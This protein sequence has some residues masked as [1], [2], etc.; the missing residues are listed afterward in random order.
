MHGGYIWPQAGTAYHNL[1]AELLRT[2]EDIAERIVLSTLP[3]I[4]VRTCY[5]LDEAEVVMYVYI[6]LSLLQL[7]A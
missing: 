4:N 7:E 1:M 5:A 6:K 3:L 2:A